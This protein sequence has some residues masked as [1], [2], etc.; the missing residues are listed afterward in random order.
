MPERMGQSGSENQQT[1]RP[2]LYDIQ[3]QKL[4]VLDG[5]RVR[6]TMPRA[7]VR[8]ED[9]TGLLQMTATLQSK[10]VTAAPTQSDYN[11]LQHD[12]AKMQQML[13]VV[14]TALNKRLVP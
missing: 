13:M 3:R 7:A 2:D 1:R 11:A 6:A 14:A 10:T 4:D 9:L 5:T 12:V 8:I